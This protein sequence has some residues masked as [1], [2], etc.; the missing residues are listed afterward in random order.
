MFEILLDEWETGVLRRLDWVYTVCSC[1][2][3]PVLRVITVKHFTKVTICLVLT[4]FHTL[5]ILAAFPNTCIV[6]AFFLI[7][8]IRLRFAD[9]FCTIPIIL[10]SEIIVSV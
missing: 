8:L 6:A 5:P 9:A 1:L 7:F 4:Y 3:V 2:S 10:L